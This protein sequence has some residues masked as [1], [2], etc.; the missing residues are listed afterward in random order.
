M[1]VVDCETDR[2]A[3]MIMIGVASDIKYQNFEQIDKKYYYNFFKNTTDFYNFL[4]QEKIKEI[5]CH[6]LEYDFFKIYEARR[7]NIK[8]CGYYSTAGLSYIQQG[9]IIWKDM[10]N[11]LPF[12]LEHIGNLI[13]VK[14]I[15]ID[16][17]KIT[18]VNEELIKYNKRDCLITIVALDIIKRIYRELGMEKIKSTS[19][20]QAMQLYLRKFFCANFKK[21]K[22]KHIDIWRKGYKGGWV[23]VFLPGEYKN[24]T[25][26]KIDIN[27]IFPMMMMTSLPLYYNFRIQKSLSE[28]ERKYTYWLGIRKDEYGEYDV[29]NSIENRYGRGDYYYLFPIKVYPFLNY[30]KFLYRKKETSTGLKKQIY[31]KLLNSLYGKFGQLDNVDIITNYNYKKSKNI[32][33]DE[34]IIGNLH[35]I[36]KYDSKSKFWVNI[37]WSLF[38]TAKARKYMKNLYYFLAKKGFDIFYVDTDAFIIKGNIEK[39]KHCIN[40]NKIGL[41]KI[42]DMSNE[43]DIRGKKMYRFGEVSRCIEDCKKCKLK[44]C[45]YKCK[46]VPIEYRK[47]FFENGYV[48]FEKFAKFKESLKQGYKIGE[49]IQM[50]KSNKSNI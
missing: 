14:K 46:G 45:I 34:Q 24:D 18:M 27:S 23:E 50:I 7:E 48:Q 11:H 44:D 31:K 3:N 15:K 26:Y 39:I 5:F 28:Y 49:K 41:F 16:Y 20:S 40:N 29:F 43:I 21:V 19:G 10:H 38:I 42:E 4:K 17:D 1:I 47:M 37:I 6:N 22:K 33:Y 36:K 30:V 13:G 8:F 25:Y 9:V 2:N 35:R 32:Y 12:S